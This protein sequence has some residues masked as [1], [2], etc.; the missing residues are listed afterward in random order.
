MRYECGKSNKSDRLF[1]GIFWCS[2]SKGLHYLWC[3]L[4]C[5][6]SLSWKLTSSSSLFSW[7]P[8]SKHPCITTLSFGDLVHNSHSAVAVLVSH[9]LLQLPFLVYAF[10]VLLSMELQRNC[11]LLAV[12]ALWWLWPYAAPSKISF[13]MNLQ[14]CLWFSAGSWI[15]SYLPVLL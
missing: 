1:S 10:P 14:V 8:D 3:F 11:I 9:R 6:F 4:L 15:G 7:I 5:I 12:I 2:L 13:L